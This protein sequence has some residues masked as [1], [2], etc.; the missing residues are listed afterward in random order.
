MVF[1]FLGVSTSSFIHAFTLTNST[2][3]VQI[4]TPQVIFCVP[5]DIMYHI[6]YLFKYMQSGSPN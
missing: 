6:A 3:N 2:F 1:F 4:V 5:V